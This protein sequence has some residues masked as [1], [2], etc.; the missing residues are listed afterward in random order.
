MRSYRHLGRALVA[1]V[2]MAGAVPAGAQVTLGQVDTFTGGSPEGWFFGGGP[3]GVPVTPAATE[4]TGGPGG[5]G[6][7]FMRLTSNGRSGPGSRLSILNGTQWSGDYL[8][9]GVGAI[10]MD[11]RNS[12][13]TDLSLRLF[14]EVIGAMGPT[15]IAFSTTPV[16][17][18][19]G[20]DWT[21]VVFPIVGGLTNSPIPGSSIVDAL[22]NTMFLR[23]GHSPNPLGGPEPFPQIAAQLDVDNIAAIAAVPEPSTVAL[24]GGGLLALVAARRRRAR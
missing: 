1:A 9:A 15:D 13:N 10:Q 24:L 14:F 21:R 12:G 16:V 6:D 19:A 17:L 22:S 11:L 5:A 18:A 7:A 8:T 23:F 4:A 3:G 2:A 20:S